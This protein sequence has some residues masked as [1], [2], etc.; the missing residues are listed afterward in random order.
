MEALRDQSP[1]AAEP[2]LAKALNL[3]NNFLVEERHAADAHEALCRSAPSAETLDRLQQL[4]R[5]CEETR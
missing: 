3:R 5:P 4:G 2:S 1:T